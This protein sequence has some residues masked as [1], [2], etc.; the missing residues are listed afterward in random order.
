[1]NLVP[2]LC[3]ADVE[4]GN[5]ILGLEHAWGTGPQ[6]SQ[7]LLREIDG[8]PRGSSGSVY[9]AGE[10]GSS[11]WWPRASGRSGTRSG[12][13][14][15]D[16]RG[17]D[18]QD[19]GRKFLASNGG[20]IYIDLDHLELC[21]PEVLSARDWVAAWYAMLRLA[22]TAQVAAND[23][24][25]AG[26]TLQ[27]L[28][29]N[30]DGRG[31]S[32]GGHLDFL[33]SRRLWDR[34]FHRKMHQMLFLA[35]YQASSI[36]FTGQGKV[37]SENGRPPVE[38]QLAQR[39]DFFET[40]TG[41]Q[42]TYRRPLVNSRDEPLCGGSGGARGED[43]GQSL[44]RLHVIFYDSNLCQVANLLKVGVMQI[45]LALLEAER[46]DPELI[47]DDP[48]AA[49]LAW[50]HDPQ[51]AAR[52]PLVSG[53]SLTAVEHQLLVLEYVRP[54]VEAGEC[55]EAVPGAGEILELWAET[56]ALLA[57]RDLDRLAPRLDWVLKLTSLERLLV[58]QPG[59]DWQSPE[60]KHL[61]HL[62]SS[63][64]PAEGL[65]WAYQEQ[66]LVETVV[67]E[68]E[69][70]RRVTE[71]PPDTR[72]WAR[73][74][75]LRGLDP[76]AV[77]R[78]DWDS[79]QIAMPGGGE[80]WVVELGSPLLSGKGELRGRFRRLT[81]RGQGSAVKSLSG[82]S[83]LAPLAANAAAVPLALQPYTPTAIPHPSLSKGS[84]G[85]PDHEVP[86]T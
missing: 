77:E 53:R 8:L 76:E 72:A 30:S 42:T 12:W 9:S 47:L 83:A 39:A 82:S 16:G 43:R 35:S 70:A 81:P 27:V 49:V 68:A 57:R 13:S 20:C 10:S 65:Y 21:L 38:F 31:S 5:F 46:F 55:D 69:I 64:D 80:S 67:E 29:N 19:W 17:W 2:K 54:F 58:R 48:L 78:V 36:V 73:A 62:Y 52:S 37:G 86:S 61:D 33:F 51:L 14:S 66:G 59:L 18:P 34:L 84:T 4:L 85:G 63:L 75:L 71:P 60:L 45:V 44:A 15:G 24:L 23:K 40:L 32:W 11:D 56:L 7:A 28:V 79:I 26:Q 1:M 25:P 41:L 74:M 3:G 50:S 6:A 22:R